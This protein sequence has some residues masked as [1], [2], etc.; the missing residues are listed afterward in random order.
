MAWP[1]APTF[2]FRKLSFAQF[3]LTVGTEPTPEVRKSCCARSQ[4]ETRCICLVH[5]AAKRREAGSLMHRA[6]K[7]EVKV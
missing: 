4:H 2:D 7:I 6:A 3:G 1:D 5:D